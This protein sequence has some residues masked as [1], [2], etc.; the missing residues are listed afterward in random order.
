MIG[1]CSDRPSAAP[2][3]VS[4]A[5]AETRPS[6]PRQA[7]QSRVQC[8]DGYER[9]G[10]RGCFTIDSMSK[11]YGSIYSVRGKLIARESCNNL[12]VTLAAADASGNVICDGNGMVSDVAGGQAERWDGNLINCPKTPANVSVKLS[13]CM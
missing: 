2:I 7:E 10:S 1:V 13:A 8:P 9:A 4:V 3:G 11:Q 6:V 12:I 5:E